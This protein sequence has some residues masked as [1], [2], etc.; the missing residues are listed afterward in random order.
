MTVLYVVNE[1]PSV[2]ETFVVNEAAAVTELGVPVLGYALKRGAAR[3]AAASLELISPPMG[4]GRLLLAS[5]RN[6]PAIA[7]A[8]WE[9]RRYQLTA[10]DL[11]RLLYAEL[12]AAH[13]GRR[14]KEAGVVHVHAH[15]LGRTADVASSL[16]ARLGCKWTATAHAADIYAPPE[17]ALLRRRMRSVAGVACAS[18]DIRNRVNGHAG[19]EGVTTALVRCG[20]DTSA[21][22]FAS[23]RRSLHMPHL[24][25]V[26]RL[27]PTKGH[28]TVL[29]SAASLLSENPL[30]RWTIV[31]DGPM[32]EQLVNDPRYRELEPRLHIAGSLNHSATL[33]L[34]GDATG[35]ILPCE[36]STTGDS[37]GI[38]V[39][40]MEAMALGVP[41]I[42][43]GVGGIPELVVHNETGFL[44][45]PR[46]PT[47]LTA[48]VRDLLYPTRAVE[49]EHICG[50]ARAKVE[51]EFNLFR[52]AETFIAFLQE[53]TAVGIGNPSLEASGACKPSHI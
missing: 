19:P 12:H 28:W 34:M 40:L 30:L 18:R 10:R 2:T 4:W 26:G 35:F 27:V 50:L 32:R 23:P 9:A 15:F 31:G 14:S 47:A 45:P 29:A 44:V 13:A 42:T 49:L 17:P 7:R 41:V 16:A 46:D 21:L 1:H 53:H 22:K 38:P 5:L 52:E 25:T 11:V 3:R 33:E 24:L 37:D 39:A 51:R 6:S 8:M 43:T 36:R 20:V 48:A